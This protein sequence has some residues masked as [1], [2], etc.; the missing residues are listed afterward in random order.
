M[1]NILFFICAIL[2]LASCKKEEPEFQEITYCGSARAE[3]NGEK[4]ST[5]KITGRQLKHQTSIFT[6]DMFE[7]NNGFNVLAHSLINIPLAEGRY[8][9][10][11]WEENGNIGTRFVFLDG[12]AL[13]GGHVLLESDTLNHVTIDEYD[14]ETRRVRGRFHATY[15]VVPPNTWNLP[16]TVRLTDGQFS[17]Q[18]LEW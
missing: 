6:L 8:D 4:W 7:E 17:T 16:D 11:I 15:V 1:K 18:I 13:L 9:L 2:L 10:H 5:S 14:P 3:M 12:D